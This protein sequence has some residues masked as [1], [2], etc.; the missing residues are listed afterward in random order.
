[1]RLFDVNGDGL[2]DVATGWEEGG[3][4]CAVPNPGSRRSSAAWPA[5]TVGHVKSA[6]DAVFFDV[7]DDGAVDVVS[8]CEGKTRS[9]FVHFAP[10]KGMNSSPPRRGVRK[11]SR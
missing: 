6:E 2:L 11:P 10:R 4:V 9:V 1:M 7:N 5:V 3:I 8:C